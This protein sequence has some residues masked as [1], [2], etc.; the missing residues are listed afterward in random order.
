M[1]FRSIE[2][3][4]NKNDDDLMQAISFLK[5]VFNKEVSLSKVAT[6]KFP[7][8]FIPK[9]IRKYLYIVKENE[10]VTQPFA[11]TTQTTAASSQNQTLADDTTKTPE[12]TGPTA[13]VK[14]TNTTNVYHPDKYEF[15]LYQAIVKEIDKGNIFCNESTKY[16]SLS[17]DLVSDKV[18]QNKDELI[19]K[20]N[21]PNIA[22][23]IQQRLDELETKLHAKILG[24]VDKKL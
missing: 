16:K 7:D 5:N 10:S 17:A 19:Q 8:K 9:N 11:N 15:Y 21:Y 12:T 1:L 13:T 4:S 22:I 3:C 20:L 24:S 6:D 18:W 2:F 14:V 23:D